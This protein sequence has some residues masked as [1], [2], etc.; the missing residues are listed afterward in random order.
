MKVKIQGRLNNYC[1]NADSNEEIKAH[2]YHKVHTHAVRSCLYDLHNRL[3]R[4]NIFLM[5][6]LDNFH[7][8]DWESLNSFSELI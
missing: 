1:G 7:G 6:L 5:I 4:F 3:H 2:G 8:D